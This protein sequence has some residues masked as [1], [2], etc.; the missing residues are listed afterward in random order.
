[1]RITP[2]RSIVAVVLLLLIIQ[3]IVPAR[4]NPPTNP[5]ADLRNARPAGDPAVAIFNRSCRDC[6]TNDTTWPWYSK[7]APISWLIAHDVN[8]GRR[9]LNLSEFGTYND[10]RK[11][12]KLQELCDQVKKGE[13]P[14]WIYTV[15]HP[16]SKLQPG[17]V[18]ALCA[19]A[20]PA[21]K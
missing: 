13:M 16:D 12:R 4:T 14:M 20:P 2:G 3:V 7:V 5:A 9:E 10:R 19:L 1:M 21:T 6:H 18:E 17:E 11:A 15:M 8:D